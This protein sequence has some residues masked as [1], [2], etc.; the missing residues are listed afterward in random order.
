M[1]G[2]EAA[3]PVAIHLFLCC[4]IIKHPFPKE[5]PGILSN[6]VAPQQLALHGA[7]MDRNFDH[8]RKEFPRIG[9]IF[10]EV[11]ACGGRDGRPYMSQHIYLYKKV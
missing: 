3:N 10:I 5:E 4:E 11:I 6:L 1:E 2:R 9:S 7:I 8:H